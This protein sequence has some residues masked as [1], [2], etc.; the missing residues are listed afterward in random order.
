MLSLLSGVALFFIGILTGF[1]SGLFG[2]GGGIITN[3]LIWTVFSHT[4]FSPEVAVH[5]T[6]GTTVASMMVTA[7]AGSVVHFRHKNIW[8]EVIPPLV[9][10]GML[11]SVFGSTAAAYSP[12]E[13][14][15]VFFGFLQLAVA[16]L[17]IKD[18]KLNSSSDEPVKRW[19]PVFLTGLFV[20]F[21]GSYMGIGGGAIA[22]PLMVL[23]LRYPM[24][25]AAG[26]SC[27]MIAF[28]STVAT[29]A[30]IYNGLGKENLPPHSLG[31]VCLSALL[32]LVSSGIIFAVFG[33]SRVK[34][35]KSHI[36]KRIFGVILII[37]GTQLVY[38]N[39]SFI[40]EGCRELITFIIA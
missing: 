17:M 20:G 35:I 1:F 15:K 4:D 32:I 7:I 19:K 26:I 36:L 38:A 6:F 22:V 13:T 18:M 10:G 9:T 29:M 37:S 8:W 25:K 34:Q 23:L 24:D 27:T 2:G 12:G 31:Y 40:I 30:Y 16:I 11:G 39:L 21:I 33:A 28:N 14:L 3:P 5:V